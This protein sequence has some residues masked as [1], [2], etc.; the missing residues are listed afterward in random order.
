MTF[1][2]PDFGKLNKKEIGYLYG[3]FEGDGYSHY[4]K[5]QRH[6]K[7][8]FFL[9][10]LKDGDIKDFLIDLLVKINLNPYIFQQKGRNCYYIR[11]E[12]K[13]F[14]E[15]IENKTIYKKVSKDFKMGFVSGLI[16]SE[17]CVRPKST[18]GIVNTNKFLLDLCRKFLKD[19]GIK[20]SIKIRVMS[21]KDKLRSYIILISTEIKNLDHNSQK[22]LRLFKEKT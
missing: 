18:I 11:V 19:L 21:K 8:E 13:I 9:N 15:F 14:K 12:S 6:Y 20:H 2:K 1:Y 4:Y 5:K 22:V 7:T 3:L 16:D 17:G 10:S